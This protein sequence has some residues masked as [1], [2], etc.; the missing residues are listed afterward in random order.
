MK[1]I[2]K[3][4]F[5]TK[6]IRVPGESRCFYKPQIDVKYNGKVCGEIIEDP[7]CQGIK[8]YKLRLM[9]KYTEIP[10]ESARWHWVTVDRPMGFPQFTSIQ[11]IKD[12]LNQNHDYYLKILHFED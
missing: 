9:Q 11:D 12:F 8:H 6:V 4:K 3:Y 2:K 1:N 5:T 7:W 10:V